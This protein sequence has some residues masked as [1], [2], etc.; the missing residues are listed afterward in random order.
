MCGL[1]VIV[2]LRKPLH[3]STGFF[4][5]SV[6]QPVVGRSSRY[7]RSFVSRRGPDL[8][9]SIVFQDESFQTDMFSSVLHIQGQQV[10]FQPLRSGF[11]NSVLLWNGEYMNHSNSVCSDTLL[12][13]EKLEGCDHASLALN[14]VEGPFAFVYVDTSRKRLW[15][16]KDKQ[17]RRSL[18]VKFTGVNELT[19]SSVALEGGVEVPAGESL[20]CLDVTSSNIEAVAWP[21]PIRYSLDSFLPFG[22]AQSGE[23]ELTILYAALKNAVQ[24]HMQATSVKGPLGILFSGGLDSAVLAHLAAQF[25]VSCSHN[26]TGIDLINVACAHADSPDRATGLVSYADLLSQFPPSIFRFICVDINE[27]EL[28][29]VESRIITLAAPNNT[30]MDFNISSALWFGSRGEGRVLDRA[31]VEDPNWLGIRDTIIFTQSVESA[32]EN[33]RPKKCP[34]PKEREIQRE[35]VVCSRKI[36]KP[37]CMSIACKICCSKKSSECPA[38][39][40]YRAPQSPDTPLVSVS[41]FVTGHLRDHAVSSCKVLLVG[42]GA[43]ELFGGYG[44]HETRTNRQGLEALRKEMLLDLSRLW[45]RNLGRDDRVISDHGRDAAH[46]FLDEGVV[47]VV[48]QCGIECMQ[49]VKGENKIL[50]RRLAREIL[51]LKNASNFRKRAIQFGTR[52]AASFTKLKGTC[53]QWVS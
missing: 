13:L 29:E 24:R 21:D 1:D 28:K 32:A 37:G 5:P 9:N 45:H 30:L 15:F 26:F 23:P 33:R 39:T 17:G 19:I 6:G 4:A 42:H 41:D 35:C 38:H 31:F 20:F 12:I 10:C 14:D 53:T 2:S 25:F 51:G 8:Q 16:G 18:L 40:A 27:I 47:A 49:T 36:A 48:G 46:P 3:D 50:L 7:R 34:D 11:S 22:C 43:D 52:L 44:R